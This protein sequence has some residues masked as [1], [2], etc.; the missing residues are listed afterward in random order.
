MKEYLVEELT[1]KAYNALDIPRNKSRITKYAQTRAAIAV[2]LNKH[3][4]HR[5]IASALGVDRSTVSYYRSKHDINLKHWGD[6]DR[7]Y[8]IAEDVVDEKIYSAI[9]L[10]NIKIV[11]KEI[12]RLEVKL[13]Y[14][15]IKKKDLE[16]TNPSSLIF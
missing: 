1:S 3:F 9:K 7:I 6:Y 5:P 15:R 13:K 16:D 12:E 14:L 4:S 10:E 8:N 2:A 11:T